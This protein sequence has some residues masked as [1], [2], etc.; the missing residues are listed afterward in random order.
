MQ[1]L[2]DNYIINGVFV[3]FVL[4]GRDVMDACDM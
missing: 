4:P 3:L 2:K 1:V